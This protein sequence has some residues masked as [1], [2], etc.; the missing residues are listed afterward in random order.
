MRTA[1]DTLTPFRPFCSIADRELSAR[2]SPS[3]GVPISQEAIGAR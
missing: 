2:E 1:I 3:L